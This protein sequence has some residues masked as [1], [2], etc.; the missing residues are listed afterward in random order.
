MVCL[1]LHFTKVDEVL[2][3]GGFS[4]TLTDITVK[5]GAPVILFCRGSVSVP[6]VIHWILNETRISSNNDLGISF[7]GSSN[8]MLVL[9]SVSLLS[10]I[11]NH[12]IIVLFIRLIISMLVAIAV[13]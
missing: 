1:L 13:S 8:E 11:I 10:I 4:D 9:S 3:D 2:I 7:K 6:Y 5:S 12:K